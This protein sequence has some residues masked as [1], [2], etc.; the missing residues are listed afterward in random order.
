ML[1]DGEWI[2]TNELDTLPVHNPSTGGV[3]AEVPLGNIEI[4]DQAVQSAMD[5]LP[6]W[7]DE[8]TSMAHRV[9]VWSNTSSAPSPTAIRGASASAIAASTP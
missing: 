7:R 2:E 9:S 4:V 5:A 6:A 3:I 1:I 8:F